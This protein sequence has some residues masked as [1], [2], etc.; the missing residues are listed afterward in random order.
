MSADPAAALQRRLALM[1]LTEP[2][3]GR[4][5]ADVVEEC[6]S[7]GATAIQLRDKAA[8]ARELY[9]QGIELRS[10]IR[11]HGALF[12]VND[13]L[14]VAIA[15][16]A[17]GVHLGPA[18]VPIAAAR[19]VAPPGMLIGCSTDD[20]AEA[21]RAAAD[22]ASYLGIG[23]VFGT[24]SKPGLANEAIGA[25]RVGDVMSAGR[26]P[27][28]GIGGITAENAGEVTAT[29]AGVAVLSAVMRA[30]D[31]ADVVRRILLAGA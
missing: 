18:D 14:D 5:L 24:S 19:S 8:S 20:P 26:L 1:V 13:R 4:S 15:L 23:A 31:P 22:G 27:A 2:Q 12:I 30:A 29:G 7:A 6:L 3:E 11:S 16:A 21:A 17:D 9:E 10:T 25:G 28:V